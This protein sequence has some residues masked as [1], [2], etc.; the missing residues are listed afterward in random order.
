MSIGKGGGRY[1]WCVR[2]HRVETDANACPAKD[3][4]GPYASA[5]EAEGAL[6]RVEERNAAWDAEDAR[7]EGESD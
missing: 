6:G 5:A 1:Y 7:W 2:H 4:M 3:R